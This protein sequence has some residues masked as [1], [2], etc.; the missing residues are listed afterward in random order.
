MAEIYS[1]KRAGYNVRR[2]LR[3]AQRVLA[4]IQQK[5]KDT[6]NELLRAAR[7][8][9]SSDVESTKISTEGCLFLRQH[10]SVS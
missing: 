4:A 1:L 6:K 7:A 10:S 3:E 5:L 9:T 2:D 8:K